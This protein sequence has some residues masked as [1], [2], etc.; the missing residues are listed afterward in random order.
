MNTTPLWVPLAVAG[1]GLLG[2]ISA[3]LGGVWLT[4]RR[5]DKRE[6]ASWAREAEREQARWE[7]EDAARTFEFRRS[8]YLDLYR[9]AFAD[10][11]LSMTYMGEATQLG[12]DSDDPEVVSRAAE[13]QRAIEAIQIYGSFRVLALAEKTQSAGLAYR[14]IFSQMG[15]VEVGDSLAQAGQQWGKLLGEL[16]FAIREELGISDESPDAEAWRSRWAWLKYR[17]TPS[18]VQPE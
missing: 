15:V 17:R 12:E 3:G 18:P 7:R 16:H 8:A 9:A 1:L 4:Q 2:T 6:A 14:I 11:I 5:A 13:L 10:F